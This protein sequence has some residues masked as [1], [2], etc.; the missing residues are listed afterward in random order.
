MGLAITL[1]C[2]SQRRKATYIIKFFRASGDQRGVIVAR[3]G[4]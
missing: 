2:D 1:G 3:E 4:C